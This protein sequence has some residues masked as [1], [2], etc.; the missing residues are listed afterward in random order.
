MIILYPSIDTVA[1]LCILIEA[2]AYLYIDLYMEPLSPPPL[3]TEDTASTGGGGCPGWGED[4]FCEGEKG[5]GLEGK[6][7]LHCCLFCSDSEADILAFARLRSVEELHLRIKISLF[8]GASDFELVEWR[9]Y[10][11][12]GGVEGWNGFCQD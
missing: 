7:W 12:G 2:I 10:L 5:G 3:Y 8:S 4:K 11:K 1:I 6:N 9:R